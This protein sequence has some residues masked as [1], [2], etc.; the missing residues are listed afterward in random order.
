MEAEACADDTC[1]DTTACVLTGSPPSSD[2]NEKEATGI[3]LEI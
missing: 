3:L 2:M 1:N